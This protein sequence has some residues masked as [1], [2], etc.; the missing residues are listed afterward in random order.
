MEDGSPDEITFS[1]IRGT[2]DSR[3]IKL[4]SDDYEVR[5]AITSVGRVSICSP[6]G[7]DKLGRYPDC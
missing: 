3:T 4:E 5:I 6:S 7:S 1:P 2:V